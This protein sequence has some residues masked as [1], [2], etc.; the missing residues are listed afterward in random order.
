MFCQ[1]FCPIKD[2]F[3]KNIIVLN[4]DQ[5]HSVLDKHKKDNSSCNFLMSW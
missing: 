5:L 1:M 2:I 4:M 3:R